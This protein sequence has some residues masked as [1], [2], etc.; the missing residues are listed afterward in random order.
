MPLRNL[1][2]HV[3]PTDAEDPAFSLTSTPLDEYPQSQPV[4]S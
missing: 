2:T 3:I 1:K 4:S